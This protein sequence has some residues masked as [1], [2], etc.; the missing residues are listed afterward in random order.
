LK[1]ELNLVI[2]VKKN[3]CLFLKKNKILK[4]IRRFFFLEEKEF[5]EENVLEFSNILSG[6]EMCKDKEYVL[7]TNTSNTACFV[8]PSQSGRMTD[9]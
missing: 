3:F 5:G 1:N 6:D 2:E 9:R 7:R 8:V 4:K